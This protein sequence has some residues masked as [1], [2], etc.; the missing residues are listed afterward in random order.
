MTSIPSAAPHRIFPRVQTGVVMIALGAI[1]AI[2]LAAGIVSSWKMAA[3]ALTGAALGAVLYHAIFGFTSAFRVL[4]SDRRSAGVRAQMIM[5]ALACALFFP[6]L[7][8]GQMFGAP[9][10]GFVAPAGLGLAVGAFIFG[11]G[12][13]L[14]GGCASGTLFTVGGGSARMV[15]TLVFFIA[16]SMIGLEHQA[17]W[18]AMPGFG[19]VS[20]LDSYSWP[21]ALALNLAMFAAI[22]FVVARLELTRHGQLAPI[23]IR[24][25]GKGGW[26]S[27]LT[28]PWPLLAGALLLA[29]LNFLTLALSGQPWGITSAFALWGA[30]FL[31]M[32]GADLSGW[33]SWASPAQQAALKASLFTD[34]TSVM[35]FGLIA[36]AML[37][38]G[39][40]AKFKPDFN[41]PLSSLAA[42]VIGGLM[43]GYGARLSYGCNIGAFFSGIAS[44]SLHGWLW[45]VFAMAGNWLGTLAR[46]L[47]GLPVERT[48]TAC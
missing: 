40:A 5:L 12:M 42:A 37:A 21:L 11:I 28:G 19:S 45:I 18:D 33:T 32:L 1:A 43:M 13:Q 34:I 7:A 4:I 41:I 15:V 6:A 17:F 9:V 23:A 10:E 29:L 2:V 26:Q 47:F 27:W 38:A 8:A 22:Y 30:K 48:Q 31:N 39:M 25:E 20:L 44:A 24:R 14:G 3:L 16:G 46:P 36:G 35:D